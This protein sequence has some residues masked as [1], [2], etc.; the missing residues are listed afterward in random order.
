MSARANPRQKAARARRKAAARYA[1]M[2]A[3]CALCGGRRGPIDY[4]APRSHMFPLS[5]AIDE[6]RPVARWREFGYDS[7]EACATDPAN[8]QPTHWICNAIASDKRDERRT[9]AARNPK[10]RDATSGTF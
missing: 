2:D 3:P 4:A 5:L 1:A 7:P 6:V 10:P 8:W 9:A